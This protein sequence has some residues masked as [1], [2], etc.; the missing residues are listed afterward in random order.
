MLTASCVTI[1]ADVFRFANNQRPV[2]LLVDP[3][4]VTR[5]ALAAYLR[6]RDLSVLEAVS[7]QEALTVLRSNRIVH[8]MFCS[9]DLDGKVTGSNLVRTV[10]RDFSGVKLLLNAA[11]PTSANKLTKPLTVLQRPYRFDVVEQHLRNLLFADRTD[12]AR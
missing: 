3:D 10:C 8:A 5:S 12:G 4:F 1:V 9:S 6:Q 7:G 2:V 11:G